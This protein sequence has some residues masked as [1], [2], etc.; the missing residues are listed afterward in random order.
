[1]RFHENMERYYNKK[2]NSLSPTEY[3]QMSGRAGRRGLDKNGTSVLC[4]GKK[5]PKEDYLY[6]L[7]CY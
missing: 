1:M 2:Y 7:F 6:N 5:F 4:I 3:Q